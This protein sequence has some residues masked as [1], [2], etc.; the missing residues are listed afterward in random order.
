MK[1]LAVYLGSHADLIL[2]KMFHKVEWFV[3]KLILSI[4]GSYNLFFMF[5][6]GFDGW[7]SLL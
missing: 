3:A 5:Q 1:K 7:L 2:E 6:L 4:M